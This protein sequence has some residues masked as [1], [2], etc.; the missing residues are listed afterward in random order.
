[1][2]IIGTALAV[3]VVV[4]FSIGFIMGNLF[5]LLKPFLGEDED[6]EKTAEPPEGGEERPSLT[7]EE[8]PVEPRYTGFVPVLRVFR[9]ERDFKLAAEIDGQLLEKD[10]ELGIDQQTRL[11]LIAAELFEWLGME[12][13]RPEPPPAP[14]LPPMPP[15]IVTEDDEEAPLVGMSLN[16]VKMVTNAM[17]ANS[18]LPPQSRNFAREIDEVLQA[19][20]AGTPLA[21]RGIKISHIAGQGLRFLVG[22]KIYEFADEIE[23][24][25]V[26]Q[27][28]QAA[29]RTWEQSTGEN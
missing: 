21:A 17:K 24:M 8:T 2:E 3:S 1:M 13:T 5:P 15:K 25:D 12:V 18:A 23:D 10:A 27:A 20:L 16:P 6:K 22:L 26:R 11:S 14:E 4:V 29:I 7:G 9:K 28:I 19:Q